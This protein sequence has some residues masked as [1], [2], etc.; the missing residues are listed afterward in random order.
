MPTLRQLSYLVAI[1]EEGHFGRAARRVH[2]AQPTLSSQIR[3]LEARLGTR[4]L[5]RGRYGA[6]LTIQGREVAARA[7]RVLAEVEALRG[8][9]ASKTGELVGTLRLGVPATLGPYLLRFI[10]PELHRRYPNLKLY[11]REGLP[12]LLDERLERGDLDILLSPLIKSRPGLHFAAVFD[13]PLVMVCASDHP[14][15][16]DGLLLARE[17]E[18]EK[19]LTLEP[20]FLLH[21][22]LRELCD[23]WGAETLSDYEGS[24]LDTLRLMAG[25][26]VGVAFLPA[27]YVRSEISANGGLC[28]RSMASDSPLRRVGLCWRRGSSNRADFQN[29]AAMICEIAAREL[30]EVQVCSPSHC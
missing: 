19:V 6:Q 18:G 17:L 23:E 15:A 14:L 5:D 10:V 8:L 27:L 2:A 1:A 16:G 13:E 4:L 21:E 28:V 3:Q 30:P 26:G 11:V 24:S 20:G 29:I 12:R 25:M 7:R 9:A 22:Q